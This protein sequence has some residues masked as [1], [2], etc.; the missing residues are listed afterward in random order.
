MKRLMKERK[1]LEKE[2]EG[3]KEDEAWFALGDSDDTYKWTV[4]VM[5][6]KEY[7][8][9]PVAEAE[10]R[11][12]R[13]PSPYAEGM[14]QVLFEFQPSYPM[15]PPKVKFLSPVYH[16]NVK[17]SGEHAGS[18]CAEFV[19]KEWKPSETVRSVLEKIV[20]L[21]AS[22]NSDDPLEAPIGAQMRDDLDA[23]EA[24]ARDYV[25]RHCT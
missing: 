18:M 19:S 4:T 10:A 6:P 15:T 12:E 17:L 7:A 1:A 24:Q 8:V 21:L 25:E 20:A 3:G 9:N 22:P 14:F 11:G 2:M 13:R 23:F 5:G 16:P